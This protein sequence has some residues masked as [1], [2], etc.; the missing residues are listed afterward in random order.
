MGGKGVVT[1]D[2]HKFP[3]AHSKVFIAGG[4]ICLHSCAM[5]LEIKRAIK[6][7]IVAF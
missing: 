3:I 5:G 2:M 6:L 1:D 7:K 4:K